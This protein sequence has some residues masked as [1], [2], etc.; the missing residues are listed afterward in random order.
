[1]KLREKFGNVI[2]DQFHNVECEII[3]HN[4]ALEFFDW[5]M[6]NCEI[7]ED[8][9]LYSYDS[10]DYTNEKLLEIFKKEKGL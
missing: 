1:M 8:K 3:A 10:E 4:F 6:D 2:L 9:S 5:I 7:S